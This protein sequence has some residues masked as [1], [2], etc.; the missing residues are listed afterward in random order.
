MSTLI[1]IDLK[2]I[3]QNNLCLMTSFHVKNSFKM[4]KKRR[5]RCKHYYAETKKMNS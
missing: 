1:Y 5:H 4:K 2:D 3:E